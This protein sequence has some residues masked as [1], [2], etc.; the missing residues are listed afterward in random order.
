[1]AVNPLLAGVLENPADTDRLLVYADWL[2]E[3]G[4]KRAE[5]LRLQLQYQQSP[6]EE[7][8]RQL[9]HTYPARHMPWVGKLEQAGVLT[10]N[11]TQYELGWWGVEIPEARNCDGT[12]QLYRYEDQPPLPVEWFDGSFS[13]LETAEEPVDS[14]H[15]E[16]KAFCEEARVDGYFVP[17]AF[18]RLMIDERLQAQIKSCTDNVF[19][20]LADMDRTTPPELPDTL[21]VP[22]YADSQYCVVWGLALPKMPGGYVPVLAAS[23][24]FFYPDEE[25]EEAD[26]SV[27]VVAAPNVEAFLYRWWIENE[28]WYATVWGETLRDLTA[29]EQAYLTHLRA[30][31][32]QT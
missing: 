5:Y 2:E 7:L 12:Y 8:R 19:L 25:D 10:P 24:F 21:L 11:L 13:W 16:W 20:S 14:L 31:Y 18:E 22:F 23:P 26:D 3:Q 28:I 9:I 27:P 15:N 32:P 1:M 29:D 17:Q 30:K 6:H 4:D